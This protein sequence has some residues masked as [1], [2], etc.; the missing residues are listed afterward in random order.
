MLC[1]SLTYNNIHYLSVGLSNKKQTLKFTMN[2][3]AST[4]S[5]DGDTSIKVD[6]LDNIIDSYVSFI[7]MDIEGAEQDAIEGAKKTIKKYHP[8]LAI[9]AYHKADDIWK[10][11][12]LILAI[13]SDYKI[14]LRH[15]TEGF[16]E[17]VIFFIP[18]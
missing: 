17:T 14:Y 3:S 7:K 10:I 18:A 2:K 15:Y 6:K 11:P 1:K 5:S 8:R 13:R 12:E 16:T 9:S 4:I